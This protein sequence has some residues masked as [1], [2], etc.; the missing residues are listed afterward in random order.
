[1]RCATR[2]DGFGDPFSAA[3]HSG[4]PSGLDGAAVRQLLHGAVRQ[5]ADPRAILQK[6]SIDPAVY[7]NAYDAI[8][9]RAL[10]RLMRQI[11]F[12][13][14]DVYLGFIPHGCRMA[15]E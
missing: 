5:G 9:G 13:L 2:R 7:G 6:A 12:A 14:D 1:M 11:Q 4:L 15:L 3:E 8:D 10:V